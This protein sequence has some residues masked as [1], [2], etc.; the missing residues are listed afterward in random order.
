MVPSVGANKVP[1]GRVS[2][3]EKPTLSKAPY[4]SASRTGTNLAPSAD[5]AFQ[6]GEGS[7]WLENAATAD[8]LAHFMHFMPPK[9]VSRIIEFTNAALAKLKQ[10]HLAKPI[11]QDDFAVFWGC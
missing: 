4:P 9:A 8:P 2:R 5:R 3:S 6:C 10:P 1:P 11:D 7:K